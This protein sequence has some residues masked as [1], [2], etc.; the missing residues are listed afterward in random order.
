M[1]AKGRGQSALLLLDVVD[2]LSRQNVPY[3]V[4][5]A[6]A[7]SFYGII[8]ASLDVDVIISLTAEDFDVRDLVAALRKDDFA[9][10]Y[11]SGSSDDPL[12][13]VVRIN[14][15]Y[16]NQVD[17]IT[18]IK[19]MDAGAFGRITTVSFLKHKLH[20]IGIEDFIVM[21]IF[22]GSPKDLDDVRVV[23]E[24][25]R[26]K[27]DISLLKRLMRQYGSKEVKILERVLKPHPA[28]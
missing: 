9:C 1:R 17:L 11:C 24:I 10:E 19:G 6:F 14:D 13:G 18:G 28:R 4:I 25:S 5:G 20:L 27:L 21:K 12:D 2:L 7:A 23:L 15:K 8:R 16:G 22:A 26:K 3:A